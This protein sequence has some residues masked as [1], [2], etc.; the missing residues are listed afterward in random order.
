MHKDT[1]LV[2]ME[3]RQSVSKSCIKTAVLWADAACHKIKGVSLCTGDAVHIGKQITH[4]THRLAFHRKVLYCTVC[5]SCTT[6][7]HLIKLARPCEPPK[8]HGQHSLDAFR[9]D[10]CPPGLKSW[11]SGAS[12]TQSVGQDAPASSSGHLVDTRYTNK[13]EE[14]SRRIRARIQKRECPE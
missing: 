14:I 10:K 13:L 4:H 5:G 11:P 6:D 9:M 2:C 8:T 7:K 12:G 3:C 1:R